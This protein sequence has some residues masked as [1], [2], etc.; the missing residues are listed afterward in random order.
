M[1]AAT[2]DIRYAEDETAVRACYALMR[3]LRP[4]LDTV[5]EY[6]VRWRRQVKEGYRILAVW[7]DGRP[8]ALAGI[9]VQ[10]NMINGR[11]LYV[12]DLVTD[13]EAR[14][15]GHGAA[16]MD[17]LKDEARALDC[18]RLTLDTALDNV[19]AQR[20]YYRNGLLARGLH[21]GMPVD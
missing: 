13:A 19:F 2:V 4:H 17:R 10:H 11:F 20:F 12:D 6:L 9:R 14:S 21:F 1:T 7:Q 18:R 5:D 15:H 8:V 16:L 3:Q